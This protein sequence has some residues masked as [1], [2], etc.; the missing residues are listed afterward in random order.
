MPARFTRALGAL[1]LLFA[2]CAAAGAEE[3]T[4]ISNAERI[5]SVGGSLT[6][7]IYA[8][9]EEDR[10]VGRDTTS[11]FPP[12]V[13]ELPDVGYMRQLS[14]EGV[15]S[16]DPDAIIMIEGSGPPEA[17]DVLTKAT[18][19]VVTVPEGYDG[20]SILQKIRML[21]AALGVEDKAA[22]LAERVKADLA[23]TEQARKGTEPKRVLFALSL[24][25]GKVMASGTG[26]AA[27]GAIEM[28]GAENVIT[29]F[30]GYKQL[31]DEAVIEAAPD[32][33]LLMERSDGGNQS[34]EDV[35]SNPALAQTPAGR[36]GRIVRVNGAYLLNFGPRT[37]TAVRDL[38]EVLAADRS[39]RV[40]E[41]PRSE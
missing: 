30:Q 6:E 12:A 38:V 13:F 15:L 7:I 2:G 21:G 8:F 18:V 4:D 36:T 27:N 24:Q 33:I 9:G 23:A 37:A 32:V 40:G 31:T 35:L 3:A 22:Q 10:L 1:V 28:A 34:N 29:G 14:P 41:P 20:D 16:V 19:P 26:T 25:G 17:V 5:V 11:V 39:A